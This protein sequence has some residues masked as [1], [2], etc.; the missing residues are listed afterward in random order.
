MKGAGFEE[1]GAYVLESQ[2][3]ITQYIATRPIMDLC[4]KTVR[5]TGEWVARRYWDW[6]V[7]Y[8][9]GKRAAAAAEAYS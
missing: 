1:M 6:G 8:L 5:R 7:L 3:T 4:K 9:A 2:S